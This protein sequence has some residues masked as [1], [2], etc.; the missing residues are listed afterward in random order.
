MEI[1][2]IFGNTGVAM[3][4]YQSKD[5]VTAGSKG[6]SLGLGAT[7]NFPKAGAQVYAAVETFDVTAR[8][9]AGAQTRPSSSSAR[10]SLS[11][12]VSTAPFDGPPPTRGRAVLPPR[13]S[14][15]EGREPGAF[16]VSHRTT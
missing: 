12:S 5:F 10:R 4:W 6:T 3:T 16:D 8:P 1:G 9:G 7:H 13:S 11:E 14:E 15:R 2:Y